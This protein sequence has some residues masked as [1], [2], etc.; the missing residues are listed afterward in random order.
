MLRN[1]EMDILEIQIEVVRLKYPLET[2]SN[3][4]VLW[5]QE[6]GVWHGKY[7]QLLADTQSCSLWANLQVRMTIKIDMHSICVSRNKEW[8]GFV[9]GSP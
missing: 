4:H 6:C 7:L 2:F 5:T 9:E 8:W 1:E 3:D